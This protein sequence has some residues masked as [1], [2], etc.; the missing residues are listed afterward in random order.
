MNKS[1]KTKASIIIL[2]YLKADRVCENVKS[3]LRQ[4][5][6]FEMEIIV[7]DNSAHPENAKKLESLKKYESVKLVINQKN[8]GYVLGNNKGVNY[9]RGEYIFIVN[10]DI[11]WREQNTLQELVDYMDKHPEI[12]V[13]APRQI[14][15]DDQSIAM[16]V[17]A[18]PKISLQIARRTRLRKW[19]IIKHLVAY[20]EMRHL[21]YSKTQEVDWLQSSFWVTPRKLWDQLGGLDKSYFL[22]MSDPDYC[23]KCWQAGKKVVYHPNATV[24][25]DGKRLS[26]GG[27]KDFFKKWVLR[28]HLKDAIKYRWKHLFE[29]NPRKTINS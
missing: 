18:F 9:S 11:V 29:G 3:I 4:K 7:I 27:C 19:P 16:T 12:G 21:D 24:Y 23:F 6:N 5:V 8:I 28:Q 1:N 2:D 26:S 15:D 22:F 17:R 25:A 14:N 10:P 20:D 13:L